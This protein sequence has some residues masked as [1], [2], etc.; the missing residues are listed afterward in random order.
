MRT[1]R[2]INADIARRL[3]ADESNDNALH[4]KLRHQMD[5]VADVKK[6]LKA[7]HWDSGQLTSAEI[8]KA[9]TGNY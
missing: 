5:H 8:D 3:R 9:T 2:E 7:G 6:R 4:E 1:A